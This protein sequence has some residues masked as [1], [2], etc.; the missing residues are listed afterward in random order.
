MF[1]KN[2]FFFFFLPFCLPSIFAQSATID[3]S[4]IATTGGSYGIQGKFEKDYNV[5]ELLLGTLNTNNGYLTQGFQQP[6]ANYYQSNL[7]YLTNNIIL[8]YYPNPCNKFLTLNLSNAGIQEFVV[9]LYDILGQKLLSQK[10][11]SDFSGNL[12]FYFEFQHY[13][14][15]HYFLQISN[16][17]EFVKNIKIVKTSN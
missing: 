2:F 8:S 10:A 1:K 4:V 13:K 16:N 6:Y 5:G 12:T 17:H 9:D 11:Q 3:R 14:C 7:E 15:G